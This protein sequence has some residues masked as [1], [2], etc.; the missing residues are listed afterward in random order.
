MVGLSAMVAC[1]SSSNDGGGA[2]SLDLLALLVH[3]DLSLL[4]PD[5][6]VVAHH[7]SG[8][9]GGLLV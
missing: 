2:G 5:R 6:V 4:H 7:G 1:S 8:R 9:R 3:G